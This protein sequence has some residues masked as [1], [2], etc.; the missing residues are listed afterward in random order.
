MRAVTATLGIARSNVAAR[1]KGQL[2][3]R[4]PQNRDGDAELSADI[5]R[6]VDARPTY[7]YRVSAVP[8]SPSSAGR[9]T[10]I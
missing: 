6:F 9:D 8:T 7:G 5:R 3:R 2:P 10:S 1:L 4:G